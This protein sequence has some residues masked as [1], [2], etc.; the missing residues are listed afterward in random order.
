V[1][2]KVG[3]NIVHHFL[4]QC[5]RYERENQVDHLFVCL[6]F[7]NLDWFLLC[8][9]ALVHKL[10]LIEIGSLFPL[11]MIGWIPWMVVVH[12]CV[13]H[14]YFLRLSLLHFYFVS[15]LPWQLVLCK[16]G[17]NIVHHFLH[18]CDRYERENQ[19]D[20]LFVCLPFPNL[21]WFLLCLSALVHKLIL[22]EIGSLFPLQMIGWIPW[23]VVVV[24]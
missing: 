10:I 18:Q 15:F 3:P 7:P 13:F 19:V 22:I 5:D 8:L 12:H 6:P 11:Q 24:I 16:V 20:H 21:D 1:L 14:G 2:C 23:M 17:P 4:H 9:S